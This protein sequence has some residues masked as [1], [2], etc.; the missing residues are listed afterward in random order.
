MTALMRTLVHPPQKV[1]NTHITA[2]IA[3]P[4]GR[5]G[6]GGSTL[7]AMTGCSK[8]SDSE[9]RRQWRSK[10]VPSSGLLFRDGVTRPARNA[11]AKRM[12]RKMVYGWE[13]EGGAS[14]TADVCQDISI[15]PRTDQP[16]NTNSTFDRRFMAVSLEADVHG[17]VSFGCAPRALSDDICPPCCSAI[18]SSDGCQSISG[19]GPPNM[20]RAQT[21]RF[22]PLT[23]S[24]KTRRNCQFVLTNAA[25]PG[26]LAVP[27]A[28]GNGPVSPGGH[29]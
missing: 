21:S 17:D 18:S 3:M 14:R 10:E 1:P 8:K 19:I 29:T 27:P 16:R 12:N 4:S 25:A 6:S 11:V 15:A 7:S 22:L 13:S 2:T 24:T 5:R 28:V 26:W 20:R 9:T 23:P